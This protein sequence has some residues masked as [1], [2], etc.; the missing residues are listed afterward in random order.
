MYS[1]FSDQTTSIKTGTNIV[2]IFRVEVAKTRAVRG[3]INR[4]QDCWCVRLKHIIV[5]QK[6]AEKP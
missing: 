3:F 6:K 5:P 2:F 4:E 1:A